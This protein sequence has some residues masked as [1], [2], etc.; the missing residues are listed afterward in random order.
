MEYHFKIHK[1]GSG[2]WAECIELQGCSTQGDSMEELKF[3]MADALNLFL[4]ESDDSSLFFPAPKKIAGKN[5]VAVEVE[6]SVFL[7]MLIRQERL[8]K[9]FTQKQMMEVLGIK[10]LSNYQRL[11]DPKRANPELRTLVE[12]KKALPDLN[13]NPIFEF[14]KPKK[15][16]TG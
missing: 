12:I 13:L 15:S 14:S 10:T 11:E 1:D 4:S 8:K 3:N 5:V 6:P 16:Q 7:A 9:K 2:F